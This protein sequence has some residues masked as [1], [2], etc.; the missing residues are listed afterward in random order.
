MDSLD[1]LPVSDLKPWNVK[2]FPSALRQQITLAAS[3]QGVTVAEWLTAYFQ[4]HGIEGEALPAVNP[5][6]ANQL[7]VFRSPPQPVPQASE[8]HE[9]AQLARTV[10]PPDKDSE[11][12]QVARSMIRDRLKALRK[13]A[14]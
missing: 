13:T 11:A 14:S 8:L 5:V 7:T 1:H 12:M 9:L 3:K 10:T 6:K 2:D 4:K